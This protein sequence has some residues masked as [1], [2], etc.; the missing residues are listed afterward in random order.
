MIKQKAAN[1]AI[2]VALTGVNKGRPPQTSD[3]FFA[4]ATDISFVCPRLEQPRP[5][6][7]QFPRKIGMTTISRT[8]LMTQHRWTV[9]LIAIQIS[10]STVCVIKHFGTSVDNRRTD[11]IL[12]ALNEKSI[13]DLSYPKFIRKRKD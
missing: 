13:S 7:C 9:P 2:S 8:L 10:V 5:P 1:A 6:L 3:F 12:I 4:R 11:R